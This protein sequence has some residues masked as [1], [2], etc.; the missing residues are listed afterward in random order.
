MDAIIIAIV[1]FVLIHNAG[2]HTVFSILLALLAAAAFIALTKIPYFGKSLL[3]V[4]GIIWAVSIYMIIDDGGSII[5]WFDPANYVEGNH[6]LMMLLKN[7]PIWWW[8]IVILLLLAF[9]GLHVKCIVKSERL[10]GLSGNAETETVPYPTPVSG[11][12]NDSIY[13]EVITVNEINASSQLYRQNLE[14]FEIKDAN[15]DEEP[16]DKMNN[17]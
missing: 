12:G 6:A 4:C 2:M 3:V 13:K 11:N 17:L 9:V 14:T 10:A 16:I 8:T 1:S 5:K 15:D 7:D